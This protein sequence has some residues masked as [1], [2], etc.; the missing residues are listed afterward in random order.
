MAPLTFV[1]CRSEWD[2]DRRVTPLGPAP[3]WKARVQLGSDGLPEGPD[4][5]RVGEIDDGRRRGMTRVDPD[6]GGQACRSGSI[7]EQVNEREWNVVI[8][9][10]EGGGDG[11]DGVCRRVR[12]GGALRKHVENFET[13]AT[14]R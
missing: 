11:G 4:G 8:R 14:T 1:V 10:L 6:R 3:R 13:A 9:F 7:V 12:S 2:H 5:V